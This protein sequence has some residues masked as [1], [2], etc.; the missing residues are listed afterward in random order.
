VKKVAFW[1]TGPSKVLMLCP[2]QME[3]TPALQGLSALHK[4]NPVFNSRS[5]YLRKN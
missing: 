4:Q 3:A 5:G 2:S 1:F